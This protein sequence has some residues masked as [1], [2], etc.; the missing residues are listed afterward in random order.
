M[1][2]T[3]SLLTTGIRTLTD[4]VLKGNSKEGIGESAVW[5]GL[6]AYSEEPVINETN[7]TIEHTVYFQPYLNNSNIERKDVES[8]DSLKYASFFKVDNETHNFWI[9]YILAAKTN[10]DSRQYLRDSD[11]YQFYYQNSENDSPNIIDVGPSMGTSEGNIGFK[12]TFTTNFSDISATATKIVKTI[13]FKLV[14]PS[15]GSEGFRGTSETTVTVELKLP[16]VLKISA[17]VISGSADYKTGNT[18]VFKTTVSNSIVR[19]DWNEPSISANNINEI[20]GYN[21]RY[22]ISDSI[23]IPTLSNSIFLGNTTSLDVD[24]SNF[25]NILNKPSEGQYLFVAIQTVGSLL[26]VDEYS[27]VIIFRRNI[28]PS[29]P[30]VTTSNLYYGANRSV[31]FTIAAQSGKINTSACT[32]NFGNSVGASSGT[33]TYTLPDEIPS[34]V[35][36]AIDALGDSSS[37]TT[38]TFTQ[39]NLDLAITLTPIMAKVEGDYAAVIN[40]FSYTISNGIA[41]Y[42]IKL[43]VGS[44]QIDSFTSYNTSGTRTLSSAVNVLNKGITRGSD[45]DIKLQITDAIGATQTTT[46]SYTVPALSFTVTATGENKNTSHF[47]KTITYEFIVDEDDIDNVDSY[48]I[49]YK[50]VTVVRSTPSGTFDVS[51]VSYNTS[52]T[53][54]FRIKDILGLYESETVTLTRISSSDAPPIPQN[55]QADILSSYVLKPLS[56]S[57]LESANKKDADIIFNWLAPSAGTYK[58]YVA[59]GSYELE[60]ASITLTTASGNASSPISINKAFFAEF[61]DIQ[62]D[63]ISIYKNSNV[64][65]QFRMYGYNNNYGRS[66]TYAIA[67]TNSGNALNFSVSFQEAPY[68]DSD[69]KSYEIDS[70]YGRSTIPNPGD[71]MTLAF[72]AAKD[73][74]SN[75]ISYHVYEEVYQ[76]AELVSYYSY[77]PGVASSESGLVASFEIAANIYENNKY[78]IKVQPYTEYGYGEPLEYVFSYKGRVANP[79]F[80]VVSSSVDS[81]KNLIINCKFNDKGGNNKSVGNFR[82]EFAYDIYINDTSTDSST[83]DDTFSITVSNYTE[84]KSIQI[85]LAGYAANKDPVSQEPQQQVTSSLSYIHYL[86]EPTVAYRKN[87]LGINTSAP[88]GKDVIIDIRAYGGYQKVKLV[89]AKKTITINLSDGSIDGAIISGGEWTS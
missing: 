76:G 41:P 15:G 38:L 67:T 89:G 68:F 14:P 5:Y 22:A 48:N 75:R 33:Y 27:N 55:L 3:L 29:A 53:F 8:T 70:I 86:A 73:Y 85:K 77:K 64:L 52:V 71:T 32:F 39:Q 60:V 12:Y 46:T 25:K 35:V 82:D 58:I 20:S 2:T 30:S 61:S 26:T 59:F 28:S 81:S 24:N 36:Y 4:P 65:G 78:I 88:E 47:N 10:R 80:E 18:N 83:I 57:L 79:S 74:N 56:K 44:S 37:S 72:P 42:A 34:V 63:L 51:G 54:T 11:D 31:T 40:G 43:L 69:N 62:S 19:L 9:K 50:D 1:N 21:L 17:P 6:R 23:A 16:P 45:Y 84:S 7:G 13:S 49:L 66:D 87:Y